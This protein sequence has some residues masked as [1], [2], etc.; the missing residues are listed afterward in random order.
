MGGFKNAETKNAFSSN[1]FDFIVEKL[2]LCSKMMKEECLISACLIENHEEKI[3]NRLLEG[4]LEKDEVRS[5]IGLDKVHLRFIP[6][7]PESYKSAEAIYIGRADI[8][9]VTENWFLN[10]KDYYTI[11]CKRI[12]GSAD[13]NKKYVIKGIARFV[14]KPV[15]YPSFHGKNIMFGL[16]VKEIDIED[17]AMKINNIQKNDLNGAII[18]QCFCK[19]YNPSNEA[20]TYSSKYLV[21]GSILELQHLFFDFSS[22][23]K[24]K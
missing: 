15:K 12:D 13:L 1:L 5:K 7:V 4:Y 21:N 3:R 24:I 19:I 2:L 23:I 8:K 11:E 22:V 18:K 14:L 6:E 10:Q 16:V 17:N 20:Y 9:V